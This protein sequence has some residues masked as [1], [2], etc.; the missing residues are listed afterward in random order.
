MW[1]YISNILCLR[2]NYKLAAL[3]QCGV[4]TLVF[5]SLLSHWV[6]GP[7]LISAV[8]GCDRACRG[9]SH[10]LWPLPVSLVGPMS[11]AHVPGCPVP[12][13]NLVDT[14]SLFFVWIIWRHHSN[15]GIGLLLKLC[16]NYIYT[17][18]YIHSLVGEEKRNSIFFFRVKTVP[19]TKSILHLIVFKP[20]VTMQSQHQA[21]FFFFFF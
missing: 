1:P 13:Y 10:T 6:M 15:T 11:L 2:Y 7:S 21:G 17:S 14:T 3:L 8:P 16:K 5:M 18:V 12:H 9:S 20:H 19:L 4:E